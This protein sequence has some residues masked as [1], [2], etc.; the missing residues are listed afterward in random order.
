[1]LKLYTNKEYLKETYRNTVFPLLFD[2]HFLN[3][4][5]LQEYYTLVDAIEDCDMVVLPID[6]V[7]FYKSANAFSELRI[8]AKENNKPLW[9][10]SAGDY[11]FTNYI[12]NSYTFRLGGFD[13]KLNDKTFIMPSFINDPYHKQLL[14]DFSVLKKTDKPSIGFVGHAQLGSLKYIKE[15]LN[16]LKL[17]V[18]RVFKNRLAD[19][20]A[21]YPSS[22]KRAK[23][24]TWLANDKRLNTQFIL[25]QN[26]R[27]G[28]KTEAEKQK[29]TQEFY[30]NMFNNAY[31][32][33]SRGV[34]NF[35][36]RFYETLAM[37]RI[38]ILLDTD[39]RLPLHTNIDW[40]AHCVIIKE[41]QEKTIAQKVLDFH[42][43]LSED[44]F[45]NLQKKNRQLW[46]TQLLRQQYFIAI[47]NLFL[48]KIN[49]N[50]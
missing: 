21:F 7:S 22:I 5:I 27:G 11:G 12:P 42:K 40:Q 35:S 37:G 4:K 24:L 50:G 10:Y 29:S 20:Q 39:C 25:R 32:F 18:K 44:D 15:R 9:I 43:S 19:K 49:N 30:D 3:N 41:S 2:M 13:S 1:M 14:Q 6:Y 8:A 38:P 31:T 23:Y 46:E 45:K 16:H 47:H 48:T 34:G 28:I 33:C 26:Y 36:V 17:N